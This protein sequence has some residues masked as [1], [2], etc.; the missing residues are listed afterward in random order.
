MP[1]VFWRNVHKPD[2]N[3][4]VLRSLAL[5]A[6]SARAH[7]MSA[8]NNDVDKLLDNERRPCCKKEVL[9]IIKKCFAIEPNIIKYKVYTKRTMINL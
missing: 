4:V 6:S 9:L 3:I 7:K 2:M 5:S 8:T 1:M